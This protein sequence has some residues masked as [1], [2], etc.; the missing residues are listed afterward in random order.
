MVVVRIE[1]QMDK[2]KP[3]SAKTKLLIVLRKSQTKVTNLLIVFA[4]SMLVMT[5]NQW[6]I[7]E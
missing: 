7:L 1:N 3:F 4:K 6:G 5:D 2:T